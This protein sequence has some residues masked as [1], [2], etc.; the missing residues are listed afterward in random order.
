MPDKLHGTPIYNDGD[1]ALIT[2]PQPMKVGD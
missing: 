1:E 2:P